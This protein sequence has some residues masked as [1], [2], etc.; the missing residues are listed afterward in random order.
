MGM[1]IHNYGMDYYKYPLPVNP[2]FQQNMF[3]GF[4]QGWPMDNVIGTM[5]PI[6]SDLEDSTS[7]VEKPSTSVENLTQINTNENNI[8]NEQSNYH[9]WYSE[10]EEMKNAERKKVSYFC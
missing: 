4:G 9:T 8:G 10:F 1:P 2:G 5:S 3:R 6:T 7:I